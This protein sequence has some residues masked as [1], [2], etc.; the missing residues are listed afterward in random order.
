MGSEEVDTERI[1]VYGTQWCPDCTRAVRFL[2][3]R[4]VPFR[5][6]DINRD[7]DGR[8]FVKEVN[9]GARSVPTILFQDGSILVE[10]TNDE[11]GAKLGLD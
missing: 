9:Q 2:R 7:A 1:V 4:D 11:L 6:V 3:S 8:A 10:P 5:W